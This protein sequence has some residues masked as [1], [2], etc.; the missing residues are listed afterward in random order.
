MAT[1]RAFWAM[2]LILLSAVLDLVTSL[3]LAV[4]HGDAGLLALAGLTAI[5]QVLTYVG[6]VVAFLMWIHRAVRNSASLGGYELRFTAGWAVGWWFIPFANLFMPYRA[7]SETWKVSDPSVGSTDRA[8]RRRLSSGVVLV[9]WLVWLAAGV[10]GGA[11]LRS[12][13]GAPALE[14]LASAAD[15]L[16]AALAIYV[17]KELDRRQ[18]VKHA[19]LAGLATPG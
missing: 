1:T 6:A 8:T 10:V 4:A 16:A 13:S 7:V 18:V 5:V 19:R 12:Q 11:L 15:V 3:V 9:W 2:A 14:L 17:V